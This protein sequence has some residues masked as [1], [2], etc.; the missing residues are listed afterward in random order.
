MYYAVDDREHVAGFFIEDTTFSDYQSFLTRQPSR[1]YI[2]AL[3]DTE[4]IDISYDAAQYL[5]RHV[6]EAEKLGRL[7]AEYL[8]ILLSNRNSSLLLDT[9]EERYKKLVAQRPYL[10]Q[11]VPKYMIASYLG[12][13]P[14]VLSRIRARLSK[15]Q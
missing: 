15:K 6:P 2:Q 14:E 5:Y 11:R 3:E 1:M 4:V 10:F 13:T 7:L 12:I 9:P 8:F